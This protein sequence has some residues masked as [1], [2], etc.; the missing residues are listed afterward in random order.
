MRLIDRRGAILGSA[1]TL[2]AF[3]LPAPLLAGDARPALFI[4][5]GRMVRAREAAAA[6]G[7]AGVLL[8][9]RGDIDL[10]QAWRSQIPEIVRARGGPVAGLTLWVDS[11]ICETFGRESG[12]AIW[13]Q[14]GAPGD[15][16]HAWLLG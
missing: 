13:R 3:T 12:M 4:F 10:G 2:A 5:D 7:A 11:Y 6:Y 8:L 15:D 9:E 16:L 14:P 1:T